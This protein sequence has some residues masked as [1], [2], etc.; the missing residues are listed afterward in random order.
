M[1]LIYR[2]SSKRA[3]F[4]KWEWAFTK[5]WLDRRVLSDYLDIYVEIELSRLIH[6]GDKN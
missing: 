2:V 5:V 4:H 6:W 1:T 3:H